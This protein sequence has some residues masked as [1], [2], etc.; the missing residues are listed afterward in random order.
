MSIGRMRRPRL[1]LT[2]QLCGVTAQQGLPAHLTN[3]G[4]FEEL[5]FLPGL[6]GI[7][8]G[9]AHEIADL[10]VGEGFSS[11]QPVRN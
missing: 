11:A 9:I 3:S 6:L 1:Y 7:A 4:S 2:I 5:G 10:H 8:H